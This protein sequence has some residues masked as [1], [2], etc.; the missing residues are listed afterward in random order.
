MKSIKFFILFLLISITVAPA[1]SQKRLIKKANAAFETG[2]Y[3]VASDI[4]QK[5][6]EKIG[7]TEKGEISFKIGECFRIMNNAKKARKWYKRAIRYKCKSP[8]VLL[9]YGDALKM[10]EEYEEAKIQYEEFIKLLPDDERG[11]NGVTACNYI[12][13]WI[14]EPSGYIVGTI[15]AVN[16]KFSD[17][18][19]SFGRSK[20]EIFFTSTRESANGETQSDIT[21]ESPSDIFTATKDRKGKWSVPVPIESPINSEYSEG[22]ATLV[23]EGAVIYYTSCRQVEGAN[24]GCKIYRAKNTP[25]GWSEGKLLELIKD[26]S[27][28]VGHPA[29]NEEETVMYFVS[30]DTLLGKHGAGGK[31]LWKVE[32]ANANAKWGKPT[33]LGNAINTKGDEMFPF[34]RRDG[35]LFFASNGQSGIGGLD[36]FM[37]EPEGNTWIVK[38][39]KTPINSPANDFGITF[40]EDRQEGYFSSS[41]KG[42]DDIYLFKKPPL[43]FTLKGKVKN[44]ETDE[45]LVGA[46]IKLTS[47]SGYESEITSASDGTFRF[48]L[49]A[50]T[51]YSIIASKKQFLMAKVAESTK[52]YTKSKTIEVLLELVPIGD[53]KDNTFFELPNIEYAVGDTSLRPESMVSLDKLVETLKLN[54]NLTIELAAN[55]DFRGSEEF[56]DKLSRGRANSVVAYLILKGIVKER[57]TPVGYGER[58]P[59]KLNSETKTGEELLKKYEFLKHG[60]ILTEDYIN[61]LETDEQKEIAH[62]INRR[63]EFK[64]LKDDYGIKATVF[65]SEP[66]E[67][68]DK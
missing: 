31:D 3:Y 43:V 17:Y 59:K 55:T 36:I 24:T 2:E 58:N 4:Y 38:N 35:V 12:E 66:D 48:N 50:K 5:V 47:P 64:I 54:E 39:L 41:R 40:Y 63:T 15:K 23:N 18:S 67:E 33:N 65:G 56:N 9:Y 28:S 62:Q 19:P 52:P 11:K 53:P 10:L 32:R 44:S 29:V 21:G 30:E 51:D 13:E 7:K 42:N 49:E 45:I 22:A 16:S 26:S 68:E 8:Y 60:D 37:A 20:S 1:F 14:K 27:I 25:S 34:I 6:Y 57:L 61:N 46:E